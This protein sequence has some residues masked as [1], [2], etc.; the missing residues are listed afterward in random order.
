M[1]FPRILT[2]SNATPHRP[3]GRGIQLGLAA[4]AF[5]AIAARADM[6]QP[7]PTPGGIDPRPEI[8]GFIKTSTNATLKWYGPTGP[9][10]I[11]MTPAFSPLLWSNILNFTASN[12]GNTVTMTNLPAG[13]GFFRLKAPPN[14][15]VG[16][17]G[18]AGCH[19]DKYMDWYGTAHSTAYNSLTNLSV[20]DR[21]SCLPCHTVGNGQVGGFVD[22]AT[23]RHLTDVGCETCHGPSGAHKYGQ[24]D[25]VHPIVTVAAELCGGCH[26]GTYGTTYDEWLVSGH[27]KGEA[28]AEI[29]ASFAD[30]STRMR[31]G[32]CHS[33]AVRLAMLD[34]YE[35]GLAGYPQ[36]L[37][38]PSVGDATNFGPTCVACHDP[39]VNDREDQLRNPLFSTNFYSFFTA[40][41]T[42]NI[43]RTN[44]AGVIT[45]NTYPANDAFAT[46]YQPEIQ[47]CAQCHNDRGATWQS[48]GRPPHHSPQYNVLIGAVQTNYLNGA[49]I[50]QIGPHGRNTN[51]CV[52]CH[53]Q[54]TKVANPTV[55]NPN[56]TG[57]EFAVHTETCA[58]ASC[59][60]SSSQAEDMTLGLQLGTTNRITAMVG[61]LNQWATNNSPLVLRTNYGAL[62]WEFTTPGTLSNPGTNTGPSTARQAFVPDTIKQARFNL[63]LVFHD[64]SLGV[65]NGNYT[66][67]LLDLAKSNV[68]WAI[69]H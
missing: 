6:Y 67:M 11:Q 1:N 20:A 14:G 41:T 13:H 49:N 2:Q 40:A 56:A 51:G 55:L 16:T 23:T 17:G 59:H 50:T 62:S 68:N 44:W 27:G 32:P 36:P 7:K 53:M 19:G 58:S 52:Q 21:Q 61:L 33:T 69:S 3:K 42:T 48:S 47:I 30:Q 54:V 39:H 22:L 25:Q 9:Y 38:V 26:N 28:L 57:H 65:H 43:Y 60:D 63:Y 10:E 34:N 15:Y 5:L 4:F 29:S 46:Q 35:W 12:Y 18:C 8:T 31:C 64:G 66:R 45:T 37:T 24:H